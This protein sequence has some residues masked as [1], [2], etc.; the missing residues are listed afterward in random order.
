MEPHLTTRV[1]NARLA[2]WHR[3]GAVAGSPQIISGGVA[4]ASVSGINHHKW[5]HK[6]E[7]NP[8]FGRLSL[9]YLCRGWHGFCTGSKYFRY[10]RSAHDSGRFEYQ[11]CGRLW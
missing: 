5:R 9:R 3:P 8:A 11:W 1:L 6:D 4:Y 2:G 10:E 7:K